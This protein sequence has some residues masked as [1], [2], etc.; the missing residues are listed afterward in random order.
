[1]NKNLGIGIYQGNQGSWFYVTGKQLLQDVQ[2]AAFAAEKGIGQLHFPPATGD[3]TAPLVL[4]SAKKWMSAHCRLREMR[5]LDVFC[6][7]G[8]RVIQKQKD[9]NHGGFADGMYVRDDLLSGTRLEPVW[10]KLAG[11]SYKDFGLSVKAAMGAASEDALTWSKNEA[12][13]MRTIL[14][15]RAVADA[16]LPLLCAAWFLSEPARTPRAWTVSMMMLDMIGEQYGYVPGT[17]SELGYGK[18]L[19]LDKVLAHPERLDPSLPH[20]PQKGPVGLGG[21]SS[22]TPVGYSGDLQRNSLASVEGKYPYSPANSASALQEINKHTAEY[23]DYI[24]KKEISLIL[25][26]TV[27]RLNAKWDQ[28]GKI[29]ATFFT[30]KDTDID[31]TV[32]KVDLDKVAA[33][34]D[35]VEVFTQLNTRLKTDYKYRSEN[36]DVL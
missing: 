30:L 25:R 24:Q 8:N 27:R 35:F 33:Q 10:D 22:K 11:A 23:D 4:D 28:T 15:G 34:R 12:I 18:Y 19:T 21:P 1:M 13:N 7:I 16:Y 5:H 17:G 29:R 20:K 31:P 2:N 14:N 36:L 9:G 6:K 26:W 32:K 3:R